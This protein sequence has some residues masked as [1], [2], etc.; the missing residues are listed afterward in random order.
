MAGIGH[1]SAT[2]L[3]DRTLGRVDA[4]LFEAEYLGARA[5]VEDAWRVAVLASDPRVRADHERVRAMAVQAANARRDPAAPRVRTS[6]WLHRSLLGAAFLLGIL[7]VA[8]VATPRT[9]PVALQ[10][11]M[12]L[13]GL[14]AA[15]S[16]SLLAWLE[17]RRANGSLWGSRAPAGIHLLF[18]ALW[19]VA[20]GGGVTLRWSEIEGY[21]TLPVTSGLAMLVCAG[22]V[23]V[24]LW[25]H[26]LGADRSGRQTGVARLTGDLVDQEDVAEVF[27]ALDRWWSR[28]GPEAM[29]RDGRRVRRV[30]TEVL[31]RLRHAKLIAEGDERAAMWAPEPEEWT[32]R[33]G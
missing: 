2:G 5:A 30:R 1:D 24:L 11:G 14:C 17:P 22:I 12:L 15:T 7:S 10:D 19:L 31:A 6:T 3:D 13:A 8:L 27:A 18:G 33:R 20:A 29:R 32:E 21:R 4:I 25:R 16:V 26:A 9:R 23:A 28:A